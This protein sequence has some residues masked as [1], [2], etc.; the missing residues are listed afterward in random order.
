MAV[1]L[2]TKNHGLYINPDH[3][4]SATDIRKKRDNLQKFFEESS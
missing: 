2:F 4:P 3:I 1:S